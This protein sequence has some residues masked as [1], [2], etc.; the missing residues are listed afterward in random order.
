MSSKKSRRK[1]TTERRAA[2]LRHHLVDRISGSHPPGTE[3]APALAASSS[4]RPLHPLDREKTPTGY[5]PSPF[6]HPLEG[7]QRTAPVICPRC[8]KPSPRPSLPVCRTF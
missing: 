6:N 2:I 4:H 5:A 1:F 8:G 7:C 3:P